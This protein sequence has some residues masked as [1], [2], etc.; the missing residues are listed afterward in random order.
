[1]ILLTKIRAYGYKSEN[2]QKGDEAIPEK[3]GKKTTKTVRNRVLRDKKA[4]QAARA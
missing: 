1:V 4:R 3:P 2:K